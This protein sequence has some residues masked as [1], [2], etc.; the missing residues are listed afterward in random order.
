MVNIFKRPQKTCLL[1][2]FTFV[3]CTKV[4][5]AHT[6]RDRQVVSISWSFL[7]TATGNL[8]V[9]YM[10]E[11]EKCDT[12]IQS[13]HCTSIHALRTSALVRYFSHLPRHGV[14][15]SKDILLVIP[16]AAP[17]TLS[18]ML[19]TALAYLTCTSLARFRS[20]GRQ[21]WPYQRSR[22]PQDTSRR[23]HTSKF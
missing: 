12:R 19:P 23:H 8:L 10:D 11:Y 6:A 5:T 14:L 1:A 16:T 18:T 9:S 4:T 13:T 7:G 17:R 20:D 2:I 21:P 15:K 22:S 3:E